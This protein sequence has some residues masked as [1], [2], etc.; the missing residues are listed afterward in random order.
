MDFIDRMSRLRQ[1]FVTVAEA[2]YLAGL[3]TRIVQHEVDEH[4]VEARTQ[5]GRRSISGVDVLYLSAVRRHHGQIAPRLRRQ[6]RD[7][8]AAS[9]ARDNET[10]RV[11]PFVLS[12]KA[13]ED[14]VNP[15]FEKLER[16]KA[17][18]IETRA[19]VLG[20]E[21]VLRGTRLSARFIAELVRQGAEVG[22]LQADYDL[23][24]EHV[25]AAVL[26][27]RISPKRGRPKAPTRTSPA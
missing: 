10:A 7:A 6:M 27:D 25:D 14:E 17:E 24:A 11:D 23:T 18:H 21:P 22:E 20:G 19:G 3:S 15:G 13:L 9:A 2:A 1:S 5:D 16:V 26:F 12:L 8:I 4:I